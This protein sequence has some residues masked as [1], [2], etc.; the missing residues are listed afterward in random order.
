MMK[1]CCCCWRYFRRLENIFSI[2]PCVPFN[3]IPPLPPP[4]PPPPS[5]DSWLICVLP[6]SLLLLLEIQMPWKK[7]LLGGSSGKLIQATAI[8]V[9]SS[10]LNHGSQI[11]GLIWHYQSRTL[12]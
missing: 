4:P 12:R 11:K 9:S 5:N 8:D 7:Q 10:G 3:D 2:L 6:P 1:L